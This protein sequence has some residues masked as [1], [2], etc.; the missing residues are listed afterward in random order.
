M[1]ERAWAGPRNPCHHRSR[2]TSCKGLLSANDVHY[3]VGFLYAIVN[4]NERSVTLGDRVTDIASGTDRDVD[5]V[6]VSNADGAIAGVE[7]KDETRKLDVIDIEAL[8]CKLRD[9]PSLSERA[10]VSS[11]GFTKPAIEKARFHGVECLLL[12]RGPIPPELGGTDL[13]T[14]QHLDERGFRDGPHVRAIDFDRVHDVPADT[15][16]LEYQD[17]NDR[18]ARTLACTWAPD[19]VWLDKAVPL[20]R[21]AF[22]RDD[23]GRVVVVRTIQVAG[24]VGHIRR[25]PLAAECYVADLEGHPFAGARLFEQDGDLWG[26]GVPRGSFHPS[27]RKIPQGA[28]S[29]PAASLPDDVMPRPGSDSRQPSVQ[30][31][32]R[33]W[34]GHGGTG[35]TPERA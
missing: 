20:A 34:C 16:L 24:V 17:F 30:P 3:L 13:S 21:P 31:T 33:F 11:S 6:L 10:V 26:I 25:L 29:A 35:N 4:R 5:I 27:I 23:Q 9:M 12:V 8:C 15:L 19:G 32:R 1:P 22:I 7:V 14:L 28:A 18:I 2:M